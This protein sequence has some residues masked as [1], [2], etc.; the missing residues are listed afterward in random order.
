VIH[1][2]RGVVRRV[3]DTRQ[4]AQELE[5]EI[6]D[7]V[8]PAIAYP[9]MSGDV[10]SGDA[11]ILN[12]TA[13]DLGLGTGGVHLV[14]A[15]EGREIVAEP[16]LGHV[17]KARYTP[18]QTAVSSVE[19]TDAGLLEASAG[20]GQIP[21]VCAPLHSMVGP[22]AAG[23]KR[24]AGARVVSCRSSVRRRSSMAGSRA[25]RR[26]AETSKP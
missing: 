24:A 1:I 9:A 4:G 15:I 2:R 25:D 7:E 10:V 19:E 8:A 20:L 26:S 22:V 3:T 13:L 21:V 6:E 18:V 5:V 12:T 14:I 11:V 17:M 23:A 16:A